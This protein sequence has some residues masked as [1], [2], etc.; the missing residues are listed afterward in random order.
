[1]SGSAKTKEEMAKVE[2][3][4]RR[5]RLPGF[6]V[7]NEIGLGDVIKR[8]TSLIGIKP[9]G[10]CDARAAALNNWIVFTRRH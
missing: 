1:M 10:G 3:H 8:A 9:C 4:P 6:L 2:D 7:E 5:V